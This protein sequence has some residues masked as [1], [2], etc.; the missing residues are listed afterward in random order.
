MPYYYAFVISGVDI[1]I[2]IIAWVFD[3]ELTI[4]DNPL[5]IFNFLCG[6]RRIMHYLVSIFLYLGFRHFKGI[7][8]TDIDC[9]LSV[10]VVLPNDV[11]Y[12]FVFS[13]D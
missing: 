10:I 12:L 4:A 11:V 9:L 7:A 8:G 5:E 3:E 2:I 6:L 13:H 1:N